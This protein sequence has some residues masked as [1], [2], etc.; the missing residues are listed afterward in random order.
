MKPLPAV[1]TAL[2]SSSYKAAYNDDNPASDLT[3]KSVPDIN[4]TLSTL[5]TALQDDFT[6]LGLTICAQRP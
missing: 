3:A 5:A 4:A 1:A 2:I 6:A